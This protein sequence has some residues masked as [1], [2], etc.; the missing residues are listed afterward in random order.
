MAESYG[1]EMVL[2]MTMIEIVIYLCFL[3]V[4]VIGKYNYN[5]I[6]VSSRLTTINY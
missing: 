6:Y 3:G 2:K 5:A 1:R 4:V